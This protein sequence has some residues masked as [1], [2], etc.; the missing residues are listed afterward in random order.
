RDPGARTPR[1]TGRHIAVRWR[2]RRRA[3]AGRGTLSVHARWSWVR[4]L[5]RRTVLRRTRAVAGDAHRARR[6][7]RS[8]RAAPIAAGAALVVRPRDCRI[9][10]RV[11]AAAAAGTSVGDGRDERRET[12]DERKRERENERRETRGVAPSIAACPE[13][14]EG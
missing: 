6:R 8:R 2:R 5:C 14:R 12:R 11:D 3:R 13:H 4:H 1:R 10:E 9:R 7:R